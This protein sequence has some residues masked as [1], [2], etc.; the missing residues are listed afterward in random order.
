MQQTAVLSKFPLQCSEFHLFYVLHGKGAGRR[1][2]LQPGQSGVIALSLRLGDNWLIIHRQS[3]QA[4][5]VQPRREKTCVRSPRWGAQWQ[6]V[7]IFQCPGLGTYREKNVECQVAESFFSGRKSEWPLSQATHSIQKLYCGHHQP[8]AR[9]QR[10]ERTSPILI[11][12][13]N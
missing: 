2:L 4:A 10:W 6:E 11:E 5:N 1:G 9:W 12:S 8:C 7:E 13:I 3:S